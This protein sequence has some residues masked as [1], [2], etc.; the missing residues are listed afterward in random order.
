M[1]KFTLLIAVSLLPITLFAQTL[2]GSWQF[3][4]NTNDA[5]GN[6]LNASNHG[7]TLT[8]GQA[9]VSNTAYQFNGLSTYMEVPYNALLDLTTWT[10][11]ATIRI[12]SFNPSTCQGEFIATRGTSYGYDAYSMG[13]NDNAHDNSCNVYSPNYTEFTPGAAGSTSTGWHDANYIQLH[14]WYCHTVTYNGSV[15]KIYQ[16]GVAVDSVPWTNQYNYGTTQPTL[17]FG[18]YPLGGSNYPYWFNGAIDNFSIWNGVL[19]DAAIVSN[20]GALAVTANSITITQ[21]FIDTNHCTG[22]SINLLYTTTGVFNTGNIFTAQL[23]NAT[24]SF[25]SPLAIGIATSQGSGTINC[26]IPVGTPSGSGYRVRIISSTPA[27]SSNNNGI[28]IHIGTLQSTTI[29]SN[30]PLC[31][32]DSIKITGS[33]LNNSAT[34]TWTG[35]NSYISTS[36]I[37]TVSNASSVNSGW[38]HLT[39]VSSGCIHKDST[40]VVLNSG[41]IPPNVSLNSNVPESVCPGT[42]GLFTVTATN[43][44][45]SPIYLWYVNGGLQSGPTT[46][47]S[48]SL[49]FVDGETVLCKI[50]N[51]TSQCVL[52]DTG[53][54]NTITIHVYTVTTPVVSVSSSPSVY[55]PRT[56]VTFTAH[57]T[58]GGPAY[59]FQWLLNGA[60][61]TGAN[62]SSFIT[63]QVSESDKVSVK[64]L[65]VGPCAT[66]SVSSNVINV[67]LQQALAM[68][69]E[70]ALY[71]NPNNGTFII[72]GSV[73]G[74]TASVLVVNSIGQTV[75]RRNILISN[76]YINEPISI[77]GLASGSYYVQI[78]GAQT[79]VLK[80]NI[81]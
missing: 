59:G 39:T 4:G 21:P 50:V 11:Q 65:S 51:T 16:N 25:A 9:G 14:A 52:S 42:H 66:D 32:G 61:I 57:V 29:S 62:T 3:N 26:I 77:S 43:T 46:T 73:K 49:G 68:N 30:S 78:E 34:F 12:D 6:N 40:D 5:S 8:A 74:A 67:G 69:S 15:L 28:N 71:P 33:N 1:Y 70:I 76:N 64:V 63:A 75:Y 10:M 54:S 36:Q 48:P 81:D 47:Y 31:P 7:A 58:G 45:A 20:C 56:L 41:G 24:G 17:V 44:G 37:V 18:Y 55:T 27:D 19:S 53:T 80:F 79:T 60:T 38:Y 35:P 13:I 23:S 72:A 22:S 2:V